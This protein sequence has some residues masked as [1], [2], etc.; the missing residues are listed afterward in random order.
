MQEHRW[1]LNQDRAREFSVHS[2]RT[3]AIDHSFKIT[4]GYIKT[5]GYK[6]RNIRWSSKEMQEH[7]EENKKANTK[8]Q[9]GQQ[10]RISHARTTSLKC[11]KATYTTVPRAGTRVKCRRAKGQSV[12]LILVPCHDPRKRKT[13]KIRATSTTTTT[14]N[15]YSKPPTRRWIRHTQ[16]HS[17][18]S[19]HQ[20]Y[21]LPIWTAVF[22]AGALQW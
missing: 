2:D 6:E 15:V 14:F 17:T 12:R 9:K 13:K 5:E 21:R 1:Y 20:N 7:T 19:R 10:T 4:V 11:M 18:H 16:T 3:A 22:S 8:I